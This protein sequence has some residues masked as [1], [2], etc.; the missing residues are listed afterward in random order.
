MSIVLHKML[1]AQYV[2]LSQPN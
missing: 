2:N 1:D